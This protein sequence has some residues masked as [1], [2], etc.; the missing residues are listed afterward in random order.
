VLNTPE[1]GSEPRIFRISNTLIGKLN[2]LP[3][4][5]DMIFRNH[6]PQ[7]VSSNFRTQRKHIAAK[8]GNPRLSKITLHTFRHWKATMEYARTRDIL[9]VMQLLGHKNI[10]NALIYTQLVKLERDDAFYSATAKTTEE[11]K[12]LVESGFEYICTT[13]ENLMLF[14]KRK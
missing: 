7:S 4:T 14:R 5:D 3:R 9:Y 13:P 6:V 1:K 8:L 2:D 11:A 10:K 12:N